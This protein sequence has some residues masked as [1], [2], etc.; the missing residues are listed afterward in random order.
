MSQNERILNY[1]KTHKRGITPLKALDKFG[2]LRLSGRIHDLREQGYPIV[3][4]I[5][6]V[7]NRNGEVSRV[8]EYR[9]VER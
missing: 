9:L 7:P 4:N 2:C 6:E 8:A 5:I 1:M 3:T